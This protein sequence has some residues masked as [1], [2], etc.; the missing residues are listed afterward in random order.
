MPNPGVRAHVIADFDDQ[1]WPID[2][3]ILILAGVAAGIIR[4]SS[5][6]DD[7]RFLYN[8]YVHLAVVGL[9]AGL[10]LPAAYWLQRTVRRR[11]ELCILLSLILHLSLA[12]YVYCHPLGLPSLAEAS[13]LSVPA[14]PDDE[15]IAPD[16]HWAQAEQP[17][18]QQSFEAPVEAALPE[19]TPPMPVVA[20]RE[21]TRGASLAEIPRPAAIAPW[22]ARRAASPVEIHRPRAALA[23]NDAPA[24]PGSLVRSDR[25]Q[26]LLSNILPSDREPTAAAPPPGESAK[27]RIEAN[28]SVAV[29][30]GH[31]SA[32]RGMEIAAA[33]T[34]PLGVGA[35]LVAA[36][37]GAAGGR[38]PAGPP[39]TDSAEDDE[40]LLR[41][42]AADSFRRHGLAH[43]VAPARQATAAQLEDAGT[44]T[45]PSTA[46]TLPRTQSPDGLDL[47]AAVL[48]SDV[49]AA[50]GA[51][52]SS[53][54]ATGGA[55]SW[56]EPGS[57]WSS[58]AALPHSAASGGASDPVRGGD[59]EAL[60][61]RPRIGDSDAAGSDRTDLGPLVAVLPLSPARGAPRR[62]PE[63][64]AVAML[65]PGGPGGSALGRGGIEPP[66]DG[67]VKEP[68]E[69][70]QRRAATRHGAT[71]DDS[72][73]SGFTEPAV[74]RGLDFFVRLQFPD[75]H[76]SL[77]RLPE[78][79]DAEQA[80]LGEMHADSAA[81]GLSLLAYL[82]AGYTHLDETHR[83]VVR[84]GI[85]WLTRH[86]K[87][88]GDL[89]I[90]GSAATHFY[91]HG[92]AAMALCE[93]YGMTQDPE[94]REPAQRAVQ[95]IAASQDPLR[96]G[97]RYEARQ[98][99]DTS[100]TGW[101]LM[102]LKS[103]Q[104]A[105]LDVPDETLRKIGLWLDWAQAPTRDGRYIYNPWN[106][107]TPE[108]REGR[109]PSPAMTAEAML[110]R[111]YLGQRR[112]NEQL[113][114]GAE[115]L[116]ANLPEV[117]TR[118]EPQRNCYYWYYATQ[119]MYQM[120]GDYWRTW[121]GR[122]E[123]ILKA[124]Q[125]QEGPLRGS[126]HP[127]EPV[128]DRWGRAAGRVY[129]TAMHLLMLEVYYRYLPLFQELSK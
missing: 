102:A 114:Q 125:V 3:A 8:G 50:P 79:V 97:W 27:S 22:D 33:G 108:Q 70:Y 51:G 112:D 39:P 5:D 20:P 82:G 127:W 105:G 21:V 104:M 121:N 129:V 55:T 75:G 30:A 74:E 59:V 81:T 65:P 88:D 37:R 28:S 25:G 69:F 123:P 101:Q 52:G 85:Q 109:S 107:D 26:D 57:G 87:P 11:V 62:G 76:W 53:P 36:R 83:D 128:P 94:L 40:W 119:A 91:S 93:A 96:G 41:P 46:A 71:P 95:F 84:H 115:Y 4:G 63:D 56:L 29:A 45:S 24:K 100:V 68:T 78:G 7:P 2:C 12:V 15:L 110:M 117:G 92:I 18:A 19:A 42:G 44:G 98:E 54:A 47:P 1:M 64:G 58:A 118:E 99:S 49:T 34:Q 122:L 106:L 90:G 66:L 35:G 13:R 31:A 60:A 38:G 14:E 89:F 77:D 113:V 86:Q 32:P 111:M 6:F 80:A 17:E 124:G 10:M 73:K 16:Y 23:E 103:A 116:M 48:P 67:A 126:W 61:A 9:L 43:P 72:G 120:Q